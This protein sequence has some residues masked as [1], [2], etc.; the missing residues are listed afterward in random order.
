METFKKNAN[1]QVSVPEKCQ[2]ERFGNVLELGKQ[3]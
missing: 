2:F 3:E 1:F